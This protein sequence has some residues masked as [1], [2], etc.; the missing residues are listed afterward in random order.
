MQGEE[1]EV[2]EY[3]DQIARLRNDIITI[4]QEE[5]RPI[6]PQLVKDRYLHAIS[7]GLRK[8][9]IRLEIQSL[10]KSN[11]DILDVE[12]GAQVQKIVTREKEH[13]KKMEEAK[14]KSKAK[15][16]QVTFAV[17][18]RSEE[19][20]ALFDKLGKIEAKVNE[21]STT[22]TDEIDA[23]RQQMF[24]MQNRQEELGAMAGIGSFGYGN[25]GWQGHDGATYYT[26]AYG[27]Y[28]GYGG[29][30]GHRGRG[31]GGHGSRSEKQVGGE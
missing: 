29:Y 24:L 14:Q 27:G 19:S 31:R 2:Q 13:E 21:I 16:N 18:E 26:N 25:Q 11:P 4:S 20:Q 3:I 8:E 30:T 10:I 6:D 22:K 17:A 28:D 12:L 5:G 1:Q 9:T 23:L 7:V 15:V